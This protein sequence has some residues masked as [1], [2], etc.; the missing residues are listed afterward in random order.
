[1]NLRAKEQQEWIDEQSYQKRTSRTRVINNLIDTAIIVGGNVRQTRGVPG[2][3]IE[4][5]PEEDRKTL[6]A[7]KSTDIDRPWN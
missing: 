3:W 6:K 2:E 4:R 1:M 5:L 7:L